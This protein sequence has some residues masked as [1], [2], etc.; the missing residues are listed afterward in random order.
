MESSIGK[1]IRQLRDEKQLS[2]AEFAK[3]AGVKA[4]AIY[5]LESDAN[6]PSIET[7][8]ALREAFPDLSTEWLQFGVG[9]MF[10]EDKELTL[11]S[12]LP[13]PLPSELKPSKPELPTPGEATPKQAD[14]VGK[15]I[16]RLEKEL[17]QAQADKEYLQGLVTELM[18]KSDDS[19]DA[20]GQQ[21]FTS[22]LAPVKNVP[23]SLA[24][25]PTRAARE[26]E[27]ATADTCRHIIV[28]T[29]GQ[30]VAQEQVKEVAA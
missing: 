6:K 27:Y 18:G 19:P 28:T 29:W 5:G 7:V 15:L 2:V 4:S 22:F 9:T 24:P 23:I 14:F 30:D 13:P 12:Q 21:L 16:E 25:A 3:A 8:G 10:K 11:V 1:R 20:A 26:L 17:A